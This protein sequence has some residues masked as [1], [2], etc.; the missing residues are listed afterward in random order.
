MRAVARNEMQLDAA[1]GPR[2]PLLHQLGVMVA[3][4][5]EKDMDEHHQRIKCL[6]RFEQR[7][8][9]GS[10]HGLNVDHP[11]LPALEIDG[12]VNIDALAPARLFDRKLVLFGRPAANRPRRMGRMDRISEQHDLVIAQGIQSLVVV[13]DERLLLVFIELAGDDIGL[14][15]FEIEAVQ[16]RDQSRAAF[17]NEA[18]FLR[19][20]GADLARRAWQRGAAKGFQRLFLSAIHTK[21][22]AADVKTGQAIDAAL[23]KQLVTVADRI[24]VQQQRGGDFLTAPAVVQQHQRVRASRQARRRRAVARQ[25]DQIPTILRA[26]KAAANHAPSESSDPQKARN[27]ARLFNE[28]GYKVRCFFSMM[29]VGLYFI[30]TIL[31]MET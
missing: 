14:V 28:S 24:V 1:T 16:Q 22:A 7:D 23:L 20:K 18:E 15:I 27:F 31:A 12:A 13:L 6:D 11:G 9:R 30:S 5:V 3:R 8:R 4:I 17:V 2:Q 25:R 29:K 26:E 10:I 21:R 19:D